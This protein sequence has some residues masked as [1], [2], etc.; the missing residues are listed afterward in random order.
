MPPPAAKRA[1]AV[2]IPAGA[3]IAMLDGPVPPPP[4]PPLHEPPVSKVPPPPG[5]PPRDVATPSVSGGASQPMEG[6][7]QPGQPDQPLGHGNGP[8]GG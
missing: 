4:P 7:G 1:K 3:L 6:L 5:P 2:E 8:A